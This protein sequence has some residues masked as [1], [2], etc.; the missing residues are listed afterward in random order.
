M[1]DDSPVLLRGTE[2][3]L[4][5]SSGGAFFGNWIAD[6]VGKFRAYVRHNA[7]QPLDFFNRFL[8]PLNFPGGFAIHFAPVLPNVWTELTVDL[9]TSNPQFV[10]FEGATFA[11][12][13]D[14]IGNVQFGVSVPNGLAGVNQ[15]FTF[16]LDQVSI[17][18]VPEPTSLALVGMTCLSLFC[19]TFRH[20][21]RS[22]GTLA[23][24]VGKE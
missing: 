24:K 19:S 22:M 20:P 4:E 13:F 6:G 1:V 16:D 14:D 11:D 10:T 21:Q 12:V 17:S 9:K 18:A 15:E 2:S 3:I 8:S 7:P 5:P 23:R